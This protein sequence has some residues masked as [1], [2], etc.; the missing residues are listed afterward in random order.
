MRVFAPLFALFVLPGCMSAMIASSGPNL[1]ALPTRQ[2]VVEELGEPRDSGQTESGSFD[3]FEIRNYSK[4]G[5]DILAVFCVLTLGTA[6][7]VALPFTPYDTARTHD[8]K[9]LYDDSESVI[10]Y[11]VDGSLKDYNEHLN[12][13]PF[14]A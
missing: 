14:G 4:A 1:S 9:F 10:H 6:D 8:V 12:F 5:T 7:V 13:S 3:E 11:E 2:D